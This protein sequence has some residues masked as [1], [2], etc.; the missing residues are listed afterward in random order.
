[1]DYQLLPNP[2]ANPWAIVDVRQFSHRRVI[3]HSMDFN[4][5]RNCA[6]DV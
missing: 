1:M 5:A 2:E 3:F 4:I 6:P